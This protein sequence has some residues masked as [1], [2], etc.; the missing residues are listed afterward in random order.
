MSAG[1]EHIDS[2]IGSWR[3]GLVV[4]VVALLAGLLTSR[5]VNKRGGEPELQTVARPAMGTLVEIR[6]PGTS[7]ASAAAAQAALA[8]V[9]RVDSLFSWLLPPP[10]Q[11]PPGERERERREMLELGLEVQRWSH[12]AF[13][14][15]M[16]PLVA[17]WGFAGG[18]PAVPDPEALAAAVAALQQRGTPADVG[19]LES[20][21]ESLHFGAWAK[22]YA[23]DR[24]VAVLQDRGQLAALVNAG[25]EV[26]GYGRPW[27]VGV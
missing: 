10:T 25:G 17:L 24:A 16:M 26:R 18:E 7:S 2:S 4:L 8:E 14:V 20:R 21:P 22:G 13:D 27:N 1:G 5:L 6:L 11:T 9:A 19:E 3:T 23:V 12:G 15:R